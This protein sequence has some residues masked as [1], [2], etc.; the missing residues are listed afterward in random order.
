MP[1]VASKSTGKEAYLC[2]RSGSHYPVIENSANIPS[3][4][5]AILL[6]ELNYACIRFSPVSVLLVLAIEEN[7]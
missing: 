6:G 7:P 1:A 4:P 2:E 5:V 3:V